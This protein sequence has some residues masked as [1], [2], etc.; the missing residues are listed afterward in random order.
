MEVKLT[1][2]VSRLVF[3]FIQ[4][5]PYQ[6]VMGAARMVTPQGPALP[7]RTRSRALPSNGVPSAARCRMAM[8]LS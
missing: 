7:F 6:M 5:C 3:A 8:S 1:E 2:G 4:S